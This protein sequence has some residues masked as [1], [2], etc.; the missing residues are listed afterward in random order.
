[1]PVL[2]APPNFASPDVNKVTHGPVT[3]GGTGG[4][5]GPTPPPTTGQ[6]WPRS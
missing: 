2:P 6:I 4:G 5:T 3:G 1:M